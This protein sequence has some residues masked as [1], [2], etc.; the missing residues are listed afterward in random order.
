MS[1]ATSETASVQKTFE[2]F[3]QLLQFQG[4]VGSFWGLY[5][6]ALVNYFTGSACII[7]RKNQNE[8]NW[9]QMVQF[10]LTAKSSPEITTLQKTAAAMKEGWESLN[11]S[12]GCALVGE[13]G[14]YIAALL[15][16]TGSSDIACLAF[17]YI[18]H[19][20]E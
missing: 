6:E 1:E 2:K 8:K 10:P 13:A 17:V 18:G 14:G 12:I 19:G 5:S 7:V 16:N 20:E 15:L 9:R 11:N 4:N 3:Q